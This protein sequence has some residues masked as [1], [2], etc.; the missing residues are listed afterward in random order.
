MSPI[1][2]IT[3]FSVCFSDLSPRQR[4]SDRKG[5]LV[6]R[7]QDHRSHQLRL[8]SDPK[9]LL[10]LVSRGCHDRT[11]SA[12]QSKSLHWLAS[13]KVPHTVIDGNDPE[14]RER[15][16]KLFEISGVRANYPQFFFEFQEGTI[17][18]LGNFE[19]LDSLNE[20]KGL[21]AEV[22]AQH[23]ELETWEK[24]FGSVVEYF[25]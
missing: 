14:Q 9:I 15:R 20:T 7:F 12:N 16:N 13:R 6:R 25:D 10:C 22:L 17:N 8:M 3:H 19:K 21:P 5:K 1:F 24:Q 23:P 2:F 11:Q 18:F 4:I